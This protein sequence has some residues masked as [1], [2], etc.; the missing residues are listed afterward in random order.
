MFDR[1]TEVVGGVIWGAGADGS[2][3]ASTLCNRPPF[4]VASRDPLTAG[5]RGGV[6][7]VVERGLRDGR[8]VAE[9]PVVCRLGS[10]KLSLDGT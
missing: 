6:C 9:L 4:P 7:I 2:T 8:P 1:G 10:P 5:V 3:S